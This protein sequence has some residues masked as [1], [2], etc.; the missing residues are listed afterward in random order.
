MKGDR[1]RVVSSS[2]IHEDNSNS[3]V[4]VYGVKLDQEGR[5][6]H[7]HDGTVQIESLGG[8]ANNSTGV[9]VGHPEKVHR[10]QL[11]EQESPVGLGSNDFVQVI[12]VMLDTYQRL[13]WFPVDK[14][15]VVAGGV[16]Q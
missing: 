4:Y 7:N 16:A 10:S 2:H 13:G 6:I 5:P 8:V 1:V 9:V 3:L 12:P 11:K 15:R 14:V